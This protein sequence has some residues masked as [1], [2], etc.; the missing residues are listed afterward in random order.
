MLR[1]FCCV[2]GYFGGC[3]SRVL[4]S[5]YPQ[6]GCAFCSNMCASRRHA[7]CGCVLSLCV[8][9]CRVVVRHN[10]AP[11]QQIIPSFGSV[12]GLIRPLVCLLCGLAWGPVVSSFV[13][14]MPAR[15][16]VLCCCIFTISASYLAAG[17]VG[18]PVC[19]SGGVVVCG[20]ALRGRCKLLDADS[21]GPPS[22][23]VRSTLQ[24]TLVQ[25]LWCGSSMAAA[26]FQQRPRVGAAVQQL[27]RAQTHGCVA[28]L[29]AASRNACKSGACV[30]VLG[31]QGGSPSGGGRRTRWRGGANQKG[32]EGRGPALCAAFTAVDSMLC[33]GQLQQLPVRQHC[34]L[35]SER[36][37]CRG[38]LLTSAA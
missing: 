7:S 32:V 3:K 35:L 19:F 6:C 26:V 20:I 9:P 2:D 27:S 5:R 4:P 18:A 1:L 11:Q 13:G 15:L 36:D 10:P 23:C 21:S 25:G 16:V 31:W 30:D 38:D 14:L 12:P 29:Q 22:A 17:C 37:C 8:S 24:G 28:R 34:V 33:T